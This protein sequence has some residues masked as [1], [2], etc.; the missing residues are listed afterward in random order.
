MIYFQRE[1]VRHKKVA[2][3]IKNL[4]NLKKINAENVGVQ[5]YLPGWATNAYFDSLHGKKA[6]E[7]KGQKLALKK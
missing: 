2:K 3:T 6:S 7:V 5:D 4:K 1:N